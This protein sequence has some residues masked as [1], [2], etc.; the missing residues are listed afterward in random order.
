MARTL[1]ILIQKEHFANLKH[2]FVNS[3][4]FSTSMRY[5]KKLKDIFSKNYRTCFQLLYSL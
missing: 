3:R 1:K 5:K 4:A 2:I